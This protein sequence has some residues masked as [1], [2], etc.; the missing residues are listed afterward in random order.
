MADRR[1]RDG[2][3]IFAKT[4]WAEARG[5]D[6]M[7]QEWVG[8]V[9]KNRAAKK[10]N[11][12]SDIRDVCLAPQQF[13]CWNGR[14]DIDVSSERGKYDEIRKWSDKLYDE[15]YNARNDPT[16]GCD[17]Y[18]NPSKEK[19]DWTNNVDFVKRIGG[20]HFYRSRPSY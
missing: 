19:A 7:G 17:H 6:R 20:H 1:S 4:I 9:I 10:W 12:A 14:S 18:N 3:D 15:P 16:G 13:E 2:K 11:G 5:E 8:R